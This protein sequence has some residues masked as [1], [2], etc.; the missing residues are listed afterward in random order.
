MM[1]MFASS[2]FIVN[3]NICEGVK[4]AFFFGMFGYLFTGTAIA[5]I[6]SGYFWENGSP[7]N[8]GKHKSESPYMF[9]ASNIFN[10]CLGL[11]IWIYAIVKIAL[12]N[13]Q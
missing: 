8:R 3:S 10:I 7:G 6:R 4:T 2:F 5:Q 13:K 9:V 12:N 1:L 11:L